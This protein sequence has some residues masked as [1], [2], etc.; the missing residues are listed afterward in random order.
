[1][2]LHRRVE[3]LEAKVSPVGCKIVHLVGVLSGQSHDDACAAY[4]RP[5]NDEDDV[6]FLVGVEPTVREVGE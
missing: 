6:I 3:K 4:G 2:Q 1:M 5:I